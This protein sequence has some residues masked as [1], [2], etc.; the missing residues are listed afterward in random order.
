MTLNIQAKSILMIRKIFL[1]SYLLFLSSC[2]LAHA[3]IAEMTPESLPVLNQ[4]L[5]YS[6]RRI[7][8]LEQISD[9]STYET[10]TDDGVVVGNGS[11]FD[12]KVLPSCSTSTSALQ[13]TTASNAFSCGTINPIF[14]PTNIQ[15]FTSSGTWTKPSTVSK[16]YVKVWGGGAGGAGGWSA[17]ISAGGGG[18]GGYSEGYVTVTGDVTVTIGS[19]G[20]SGT[21]GGNSSFAGG[22]TVQG[23][24]G[25][26]GSGVTAGAGGAA[27][28]GTINLTGGSGQDGAQLSPGGQGGSSRFGGDGGDGGSYFGDYSGV[29][30]SGRVGG[31]PGGG[32]GGTG[33][34]NSAGSAGSGG[35]GMVIVYY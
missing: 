32:G 16:V 21:N 30:A 8:S 10:P 3:Q 17:T 9:L 12:T 1:T 33:T 26:T 5:R 6:E 31:T 19:G 29:S 34:G 13:Y 35:P 25:S 18:G 14:V 11:S 27:S 7:D 24:G 4:Q 23:N 2:N 22:V 20:A 15:V 28:G